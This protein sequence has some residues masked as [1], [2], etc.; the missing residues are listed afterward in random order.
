MAVQRLTRKGLNRLAPTIVS[1]AQA[2]GLTAHAESI[3]VRIR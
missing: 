3:Q 2:E 1:L